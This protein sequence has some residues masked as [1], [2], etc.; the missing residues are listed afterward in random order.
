MRTLAL[1]AVLLLA[2]GP[3]PAG[4][5]AEP[6]PAPEIITT[7]SGLRYE[8]LEPGEEGTNPGP[9]DWVTVHY[10]GTDEDGRVFDASARRGGPV[11]FKLGTVIPGWNEGI[12]LMTVGAKF[13]F[14]VPSEL[15][16]GKRG[17]P[18]IP[19]DSD[20]IFVVELVGVEKGEPIPEFRPG[21]PDAQTVTGSGIVWE[22]LSEGAG[23]TPEKGQ[24]VTIR[25]AL[26]NEKGRHL[27]ST[28]ATRRK[29]AGPVEGLRLGNRAQE[30]LK[31][32]PFLMK[33]GGRYRLEVPPELCWGRTPVPEL[34]LPANSVTIWELELM[35]I[36]EIPDYA[37]SDPEK[38]VVTESG[39][40]YEVLSEGDGASPGATDRVT[41]HYTG[42]T[43]DGKMFD[44]SHARGE[45]TS[46]ALNRVIRGWAEGLQLMK[47]GGRTRFTIPSDLA[48]GM[49]PP[50]GSGIA[51]GATLVFLVE[52]IGVGN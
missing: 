26:W 33:V 47:V 10:T 51:P 13:R 4:E 24:G 52:L 16:Y 41:V 31:E 27:L 46:F 1:A 3:L 6:A 21:D 43:E 22:V 45:P 23:E 32:V 42:W 40:A 35:S 44:S 2:V 14:L 36:N 11:E 19:P 15:A 28:A 9:H 20:L 8:V 34:R 25:F 5:E 38:L 39:L 37:P 29:I 48:Y 17:A 30:F 18:G 7:D 50:P 12:P 49:R